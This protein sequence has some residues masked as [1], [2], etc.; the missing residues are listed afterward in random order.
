MRRQSNHSEKKKK[1][2]D[3]R[4]GRHTLQTRNGKYK[5]RKLIESSANLSGYCS[6]DGHK[7]EK[8]YKTNEP[9]EGH[10]IE[11]QQNEHGQN[12]KMS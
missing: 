10:G 11:N 1:P 7:D 3:R 6:G 9:D 12:T 5:I 8:Y 2:R 4:T